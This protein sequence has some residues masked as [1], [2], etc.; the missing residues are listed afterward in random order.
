MNKRAFALYFWGSQDVAC[1]NPREYCE[2]PRCRAEQRLWEHIDTM[3]PEDKSSMEL[4]RH[5][6]SW[7]A[8]KVSHEADFLRRMA[9]KM[10]YVPWCRLAKYPPWRQES[11][12]VWLDCQRECAMMHNDFAFA[13]A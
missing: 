10:S 7:P 6:Q 4:Y 5:Y 13:R 12:R 8:D 1:D 3:N 11:R 9:R 2:C